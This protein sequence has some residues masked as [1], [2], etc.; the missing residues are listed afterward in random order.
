VGTLVK[1]IFWFPA[2]G[3]E[4]LVLAGKI[5]QNYTKALNPDQKSECLKEFFPN[6][7]AGFAALIWSIPLGVMIGAANAGR[8]FVT[9]LLHP[10]K[11]AKMEAAEIDLK[12]LL[13]PFP[14]GSEIAHIVRRLFARQKEYVIETLKDDQEIAKYNFIGLMDERGNDTAY[15]LHKL[16]VLGRGRG[17]VYEELR[18]ILKGE[19]DFATR[20]QAAAALETRLQEFKDRF[21]ED[22][23][24]PENAV[25]NPIRA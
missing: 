25:I 20:L 7:I 6:L 5:I 16:E 23:T 22:T 10:L 18:A 3:V 15:L 24:F 13:A 9:T 4:C 14:K 17:E 19:G 21:F 1:W 11:T 2:R 12:T 8:L